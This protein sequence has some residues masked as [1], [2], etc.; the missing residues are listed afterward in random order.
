MNKVFGTKNG[1]EPNEK[2][3]IVVTRETSW[4]VCDKTNTLTNTTEELN[5][6]GM[7][8]KTDRLE[9]NELGSSERSDSLH[10][11]KTLEYRRVV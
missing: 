10:H 2:Y 5:P 7:N 1:G 6:E 3:E 11:G 9:N 8:N 4:G